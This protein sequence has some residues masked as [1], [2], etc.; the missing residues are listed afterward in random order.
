MKKWLGLWVIFTIL[1]LPKFILAEE[2]KNEASAVTMEDMVVT[3]TRTAREIEKVPA[4]ITVIDEN[5]INLSNAKTV[6]DLL[7]SQEGIVVRDT[8]GNGKTAQVDMR[9]FGETAAYN[10]L[11]LVDGRRV[12]DIDLSGVDWTQIPLEQIERVEIVRGTGSVLYGDNA[13]GGVINII[14][15]TPSEKFTASVEGIVGSYERNKERV[16]I[17][18]GHGKIAASLFASHDSTEGYRDNN[19][20]RTKDVGG[21]F[22]FDPTEFLSFNLSG[23]YHCDD[24]GLPGSLTEEELKIDR[25]ST[26]SPYDNAETRDKY[27]KLGFELDMKKYGNFI[28]DFSYRDR[29]SEAFFLTDPDFPFAN[30]YHTDTA[31]I[32]PRYLWKGNISEHGNTF[33]AGVDFYWTEQDS[34]SFSGVFAPLPSSPTGISEINRDSCGVYLNDE[35]SIFENLILSLGARHEEVKYDLDVRDLN[36]FFPLDPLDESKTERENAF[37][38]GLT[39]RYKDKSSVF[40]RANRSFRFPLTDELVLYDWNTGEIRVNP[41]LKPQ[42]GK[43]YEV[44]IRHYFSPK[45]QANLTL[46]RMEIDDEILFDNLTYLNVNYPETVHK[47]AELG[48]RADLFKILT[49]FG[50]YTYEDAILG[51][52]PYKD[53]RIPAVPRHKA[54][55]GF[56]IHDIVP[57]LIFSADY[58]Y[59]GS[60]CLISDFENEFEKL[61]D[62]YAINAKIS[63]EWRLFKGFVGVNNL[64]DEEYSDYGVIGGTPVGRN[65]YPSPERNWFAGIQIEY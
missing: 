60:R 16:S 4:N 42:T 27:V 47:G 59:V 61:E 12:N 53:N 50:N 40:A 49:V 54:N 7:R 39:F 26:E 32:T 58:N 20:F 65:F 48:V 45:I 62:Y 29:D 3:A 44:G 14:T 13:V 19:E 10:N 9:G 46:Y 38:A 21:K 6:T 35:F 37:N 33:I 11:V 23:S 2:K 1:I 36:E 22:V 41:D 43:H 5:D 64:T 18:G 25:R 55:L 15:K 24:Y 28:T 57:G 31:G 63:Y 34:K 8:L 56:S 52:G 30:D 17:A 51:E